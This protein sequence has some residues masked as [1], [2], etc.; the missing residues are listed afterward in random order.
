MFIEDFGSFLEVISSIPG[1]ILLLGDFNVH[2]NEPQDSLARTFKE[3][4][5]AVGM[6]QHVTGATHK[7]GN[8]LDLVINRST[9]N[10]IA[11]AVRV[12]PE[13]FSDH[14]P[15]CGYLDILPLKRLGRQ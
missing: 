15:V 11:G 4:L 8:T 5:D 10:V 12:F 7:S 3:M 14:Y 2:V 9:S 1:E 13:I 6:K